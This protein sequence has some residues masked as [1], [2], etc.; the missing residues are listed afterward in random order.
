MPAVRILEAAA[1][2]ATGA[3]AWYESQRAGL[4][5]DFREERI[6]LKRFPFSV[7]FVDTG[8]AKVVLAVAHHR[9]RPAYWRGRVSRTGLA[10]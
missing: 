9:R 6:L 1:A 2:E 5:A 4:G 3:A 10:R 7:V 8:G